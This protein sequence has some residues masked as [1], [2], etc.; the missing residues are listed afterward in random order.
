MGANVN[1]CDREKNTALHYACKRSFD[2][3]KLLIDWGAD[4]DATNAWNRSPIR[5]AIHY[6]KL[7]II[8]YLIEM[9]ARVSP[10]LLNMHLDRRLYLVAL[11]E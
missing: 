6:E 1:L 11:V 10:P 4:L 3:V 2:L 5:F 9:G 7:D 8:N